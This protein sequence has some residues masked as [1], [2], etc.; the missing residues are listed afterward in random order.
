MVNG[1]LQLSAAHNLPQ[2]VVELVRTVPV[3]KGMAGLATQTREPMSLCNL[4]TDTTGHARPAAKTTGI[5]GSIAVPM[6]TAREVRGVLGLAKVAAHDWT[7][8]ENSRLLAL[9]SGLGEQSG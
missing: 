3:G 2:S 5:E 4:Q 7:D 9:A 8:A 1:V 6:L